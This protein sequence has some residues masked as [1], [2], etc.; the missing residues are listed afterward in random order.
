M[1]VSGDLPA[2]LKQAI[3][4]QLEGVSRSELG[5]A[6]A[7]LSEQ[8]RAGGGSAAALSGHAD[9]LS[10]LAARMP[11]TYAANAAALAEVRRRAPAFLPD[12]LLD[13]GAGSGAA[14]WAAFDAWP[15][16]AE[17]T[18]LDRH[19]AFLDIVGSLVAGSGI[20]ALEASRRLVLD[21]RNVGGSGRSAELVIASYA[22]IEL[23]VDAVAAAAA[24]FWRTTTGILILVEPGTP[25]GFARI[26]AARA[27]L[28][29]AGAAIVAP[30]PH[31]NACPIVK[32]DWCHFSERLPRS[33]D[34]RLAK[35]AML[36]FEDEKYSYAAFARPEVALDLPSARV[37]SAPR[38]SKADIRLKLCTSAGLVEETV[39]RRDKAAYAEARRLDWGDAL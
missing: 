39:P 30:C 24:D 25:A 9:I 10:Y 22:L 12:S 20:P 34:H 1:A 17:V 23:P 6:S 2:A 36:G 14:S 3:E 7:R 19:Q 38:M 37:L 27:A 16:I 8:Y 5:K 13:I 21:M 32:P 33:R 11:A 15:A 35:S 29:D 18:M 4:R 28:L 31:R 26:R